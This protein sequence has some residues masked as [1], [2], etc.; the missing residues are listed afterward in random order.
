M[1][2]IRRMVAITGVLL[3]LT[4]CA[5][6]T[7]SEAAPVITVSPTA[8][9]PTHVDLYANASAGN[10]G[11]PVGGI[12]PNGAG[13][14]L[15][16]IGLEFTVDGGNTFGRMDYPIPVSTITDFAFIGPHD[17]VVGVKDFFPI[18]KVSNDAGATWKSL[19]LPAGSGNAGFAR[20][21]TKD[22]TIIGM[23]VTDVSSSNYSDA[24]WYA[25]SD[26][27]ATW[28]HHSMPSGGVITQA[29]SILWLTAGPQSTSLY[30]S[31]DLGMTWLKVSIPTAASNDGAA[32]TV[33]GM[34]KNGNVVLV[35]TTPN[36]GLVAT[37]PSGH[38]AA[39]PNLTI[40][41]SSNSGVSWEPLIYMALDGQLGS[42]IPIASQIIGNMIWLG[43]APHG[44][45]FLVS[46]DGSLT[47]TSSL[48]ALHSGDWIDS[49][50]ASGN[51]SAWVSTTK[52]ECP[53]GKTSCRQ[54]HTLIKTDDN[55]KTWSLVD[56]ARMPT[57]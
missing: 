7:N 57:S 36:V 46:S 41:V 31:V 43:V 38:A 10:S 6:G 23:I 4:S 33:S 3:T 26:N 55:G 51:S 42:G 53:S 32:L 25:T 13:W 44:R 54:V 27:G 11:G 35:A 15:T 2:I 37:T 56:L 34:L 22:K 48:K 29:G 50:G 24:E 49:I 40:Y 20:L 19:T 1:S 30:R 47:T 21:R 39:P 45:I 12:L 28:T 9:T 5:F 18:M 17:V 52:S 8:T 16:T 14:V